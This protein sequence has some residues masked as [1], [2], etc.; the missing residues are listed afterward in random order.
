MS[1]MRIEVLSKDDAD[2]SMVLKHIAFAH[3]PPKVCHDA[4]LRTYKGTVSRIQIEGRPWDRFDLVL[5]GERF[6][7]V[8][9]QDE[10]LKTNDVRV[11]IQ[12]DLNSPLVLHTIDFASENVG[13]KL[14]AFRQQVNKHHA[15]RYPTAV[16]PLANEINLGSADSVRFRLRAGDDVGLLPEFHVHL[17][18]HFL[19]AGVWQ[20]DTTRGVS[21]RVYDT[22]P[23]FWYGLTRYVDIKVGPGA[24]R[25]TLQ[26]DGDSIAYDLGEMDVEGRQS[27]RILRVTL[28]EKNP[29]CLDL[30]RVEEMAVTVH[31]KCPLIRAS[32]LYF[33]TA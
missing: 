9:G 27:E 26:V 19:I 30:S 22:T 18:G 4:T 20:Y 28:N 21:M 10:E 15:I 11:K 1:N 23:L 24:G 33:Q 5:N 29:F 32:Q 12:G 8:Y 14:E 31:G 2:A 6:T 25:V 17:S 16:R 13:L 3:P 7:G